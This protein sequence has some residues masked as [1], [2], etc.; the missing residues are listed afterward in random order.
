MCHIPHNPDSST[1]LLSLGVPL[2]QPSLAR[3][4][5][6]ELRGPKSVG[7]WVP[8]RPEGPLPPGP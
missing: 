8:V 3:G 5:W 4:V 2:G 7:Y 6:F 1:F